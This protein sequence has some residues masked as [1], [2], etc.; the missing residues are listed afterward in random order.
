MKRLAILCVLAV[1]CGGCTDRC[2]L[3]DRVSA[4]ERH[5]WP[6]PPLPDCL[7]PACM[8]EIQELREEVVAIRRTLGTIQSAPTPGHATPLSVR[9]QVDQ[10]REDVCKLRKEIE[11]LK[12]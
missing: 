1:V 8:C 9:E 11:R 12:K 2:Q 7:E 3:S 5:L 4:I 10:L 6:A